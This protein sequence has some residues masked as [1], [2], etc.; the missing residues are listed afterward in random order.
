MEFPPYDWDEAGMEHGILTGDRR[1]NPTGE[2]IAAFGEFLKRAPVQ[3][4]PPAAHTAVCI[5]GRDQEHY[6]LVNAVN[7]L[8]RQAGLTL[9]FAF[10]E[11]EIPE[12]PCYF[13]PCMKRKGGL[14]RAAF[15]E[16]ARRVEAGATLCVTLDSDACP[17]E[18]AEFFGAEIVSRRK[19]SSVRE[20]AL[21]LGGT[22]VKLPL[23][24][25]YEFKLASRGAEPL[26]DSGT[27][28]EFR[29]G[30]GRVILAALPLEKR[31]LEIPGSFQSIP[32]CEFYRYCGAGALAGERLHPECREVL[33]S[34]HPASDSLC[35]AVVT[36][37][38]PDAREVAL[39]PAAGWRIADC[40][41][42][43]PETCLRDEGIFLPGNGGALLT[44][45]RV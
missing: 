10:C 41:S 45:E 18:M 30:G 7:I 19:G 4:L 24:P 13:L 27:F 35:Y 11:D 42:D 23:A 9:K 44:L 20:Y 17:V 21:N 32:A 33:L 22:R 31:M 16:L 26:D 28:L 34:E 25:A 6:E 29:R 5:L 3:A 15:R 8:A 39:H 2:A 36:N 43:S 1:L 40:C 14:N 38:S 37:C 12:A